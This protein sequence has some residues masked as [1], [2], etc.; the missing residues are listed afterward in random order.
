MKAALRAG[1]RSAASGGPDRPTCGGRRTVRAGEREP[2]AT[3]SCQVPPARLWWLLPAVCAERRCGDRYRT[4]TNQAD[5]DGWKYPAPGV[6][7]SRSAV[8]RCPTGGLYGLPRKTGKRGTADRSTTPSGRPFISASPALTGSPR[9]VVRRW[10]AVC[11]CRLVP[12]WAGSCGGVTGLSLDTT[13]GGLLTG[14]YDGFFRVPWLW[15]TV[16]R[17]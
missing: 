9:R 13:A 4:G 15:L 7:G 12:S 6:L 11:G 17:R 2:P 10:L 1:P 16:G 14:G 5:G 3:A 8:S